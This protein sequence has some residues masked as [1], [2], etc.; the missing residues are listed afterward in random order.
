MDFGLGDKTALV[1]GSYRGTGA[2]IAK[3]LAAEGATVFVHGLEAGQPDAVVAQ[4]VAEG[5]KAQAVVADIRGADG[6]GELEEL[7]G[8]VDVLVANHG[9]P[10]GSRWDTADLAMW[11][12]EWNNNVLVGVSAAQAAVA[13]MRSRGWGRI[14]FLGTVGTRMPGQRNPGYY[15]A[16]A[17]LPILVRS[18]A[19]ELRGTGVTTNLV[20]P[21]MIATAEVRE[22]LTR[23]AAREDVGP[24][25]DEV[26]AW[27]AATAMP[28]LTGRIA[29][30]EDI[31]SLV[32]YVASEAAW[33][34]NGADLAID[35]G[36]VDAR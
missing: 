25:W 36:A 1:T 12:Q 21:G 31:G 23:R 33:H 27:A 24:N 9:A 29:E 16:K 22:M 18:L 10:V 2:G 19:M 15:A 20:S 8:T 30:P 3:V 26:Q 14:V 13:G 35:G 28:N 7:L 17:G 4:I 5:G 34:I 11:A 32:A 6:V